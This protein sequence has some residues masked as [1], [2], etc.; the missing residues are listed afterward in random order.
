MEGQQITVRGKNPDNVNG[1][2][3]HSCPGCG[4]R[5][6]G[7]GASLCPECAGLVNRYSDVPPVEQARNRRRAMGF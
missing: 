2:H 3:W 5:C 6:T 4:R 1:H 7:V